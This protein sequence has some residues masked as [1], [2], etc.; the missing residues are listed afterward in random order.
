MGDPTVGQIGEVGQLLN[1]I[2]TGGPQARKIMKNVE[3][4]D[5]KVGELVKKIQ[6]NDPKVGKVWTLRLSFDFAL[7]FYLTHL[8]SHSFHFF[9]HLKLVDNLLRIPPK[10][11][12]LV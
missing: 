10:E 2:E 5:R 8:L 1:R 6:M 4:G 7:P 12:G 11:S 3:K 9:P